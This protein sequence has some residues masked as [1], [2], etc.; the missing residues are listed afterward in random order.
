MIT[1]PNIDSKIWNLEDKVLEIFQAMQTNQQVKICLNQEGPCAESLGLYS[2]LDKL[3]A[4]LDFAKHNISILTCNQ[5][6]SHGEYTI[7]KTPP[8]YVAETQTFIKNNQ[9]LLHEKTFND[10]FN[11]FGLFIGRSNFLRLWLGAEVFDNYRDQSLIT[12]HYDKA[13]D[14]HREHLGFDQLMTRAPSID[15]I[16]KTT[17]LI[18]QAPLKLDDQIEQ[19]PL[20]SPAHLGIFK[21]YHKFFVEIVCETY[22]TGNTF[23]PTEKIWR[24]I[25]LKTPFIIQGPVDYYKNLKKIGF[26][27]FNSYWDEGFSE[28]PYDYQ[29]VEILQVLDKLGR[30]TTKELQSMYHDMA[31]IIEHNYNTFM[32]LKKNDFRKIFP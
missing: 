16:Q 25:V 29:P 8:L 20:L 5:L 3:C 24:P 18:K 26:K 23:Y 1:L 9:H 7:N 27:T 14:F 17:N 32:N 31:P 2:L 15:L 6:E 10:Q 22:F 30:M 12:F 21:L 28:D 4:R 11:S 13:V 19:Y